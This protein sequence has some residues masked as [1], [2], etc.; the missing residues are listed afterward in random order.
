MDH[1][2]SATLKSSTVLLWQELV[3]K[4]TSR[5]SGAAIRDSVEQG[6]H[7]SPEEDTAKPAVSV[8][9]FPKNTNFKFITQICTGLIEAND[10]NAIN[11]VLNPDIIFSDRVYLK[12]C[13]DPE[14]VDG[15]PSRSRQRA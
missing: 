14:K 6:V 13:N 2:P 9:I 1:D 7:L 15:R 3:D 11:L 10:D 5:V 12:L 4:D 8:A